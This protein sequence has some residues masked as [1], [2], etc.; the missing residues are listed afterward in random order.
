MPI[1]LLVLGLLALG[2]VG[3]GA[4]TKEASATQAE[5]AQASRATPQGKLAGGQFCGGIAAIQCPEGLICVDDPRDRCDPTQSGRD[6]GGVCISPDRGGTGGSGKPRCDYKD[7]SMRYSSRDPAQCAAL[8]FQ[9]PEG[10]TPFF[11]DCGCG[12]RRAESTCD[13]EDPN[14]RYVSQDPEQCAVLRF[15][16]EEGESAFFDDCGCGCEAGAA[17]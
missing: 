8:L 5:A 3:Q 4:C 16:C 15:F 12:C 10:A 11:N 1:R 17:P 13:Y 7:P 2:A 6:C 14:R 9:C